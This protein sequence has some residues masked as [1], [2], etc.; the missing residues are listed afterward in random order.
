M[1]ISERESETERMSEMAKWAENEFVLIDGEEA[2]EAVRL[3]NL[4]ASEV[5][6]V[7]KRS[8]DFIDDKTTEY[9]VLFRGSA[10]FT[11]VEA[12]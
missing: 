3:M 9:M 7:W 2:E 1:H 8:A 5:E 10:R 12:M 6:G 11:Y 4:P